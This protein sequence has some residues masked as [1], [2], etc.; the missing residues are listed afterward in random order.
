MDSEKR[1]PE[2]RCHPG[3]A[4]LPPVL[5]CNTRTMPPNPLQLG[6][7]QNTVPVQTTEPPRKCQAWRRCS[8]NAV[9]TM[10]TFPRPLPQYATACSNLKADLYTVRLPSLAS[11]SQAP[12]H[13]HV[14]DRVE[15][16]TLGVQMTREKRQVG[17]GKGRWFPRKSY[18][19]QNHHQACTFFTG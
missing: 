12:P 13:K 5:M 9:C 14:K 7:D 8:S 16:I 17:G 18:P 1:L 6:V 4:L 10:P 3:H 11:Y 2:L 15:Q 19:A